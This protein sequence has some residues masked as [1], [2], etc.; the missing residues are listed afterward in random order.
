MRKMCFFQNTSN[1]IQIFCKIKNFEQI[2]LSYYIR[3]HRYDNDFEQTQMNITRD[4]FRNRFSHDIHA[5]EQKTNHENIYSNHSHHRNQIQRQNDI[6]T[7]WRRTRV[8]H[9]LKWLLCIQKHY[10]WIF[11]RWYFNTKRS[12]RT[13]RWHIVDQIT[14]N[15]IRNRFICLF[16]I[17]S[18]WNRWLHNESYI[19][20]KA[21]MKNIVRNDY[22]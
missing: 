22:R 2:V 8:K 10:T 3:F 21:W 14:N 19:F 12:Q 5:R 17:V 9:C 11:D 15:E 18:Q 6:C 13:I 4:M 20:Q 16:M 1:C 7:F